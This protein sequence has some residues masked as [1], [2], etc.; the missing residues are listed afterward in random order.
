MVSCIQ[1]KSYIVTEMFRIFCF[2][3]FDEW[4]HPEEDRLTRYKTYFF[5][6]LCFKLI[7]PILDNEIRLLCIE[8]NL[9]L[10]I[11]NNVLSYT[12][13]CLKAHNLQENIN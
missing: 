13:C 7:I 3:D 10:I 6:L 4:S 8:T 1:N 12:L 9:F 2:N 5:V 11:R